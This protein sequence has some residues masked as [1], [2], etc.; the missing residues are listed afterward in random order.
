MLDH[1][2]DSLAAYQAAATF[3]RDAAGQERARE[4]AGGGLAEAFE[5]LGRAPLIEALRAGASGVRLVDGDLVVE[6]Q[7]VGEGAHLQVSWGGVPAIDAALPLEAAG[8][9]GLVPAGAWVEADAGAMEALGSALWVVETAQGPRLARQLRPSEAGGALPVRGLIPAVQVAE[10][11]SAAFRRAHGV[12][13]AYVAGAMAG[14]I[15]S[16]ALV[17]AMSESGLLAFY[18]SGGLPIEAVDAAVGRLAAR[19]GGR[20]WGANLLHNPVEPGV[21]MATVA[22]YLQHGVRAIEASAFM[23]LTPAVVRFRF[24]GAAEHGPRR[25]MAKVSRAEVAEPFL[26]PPPEP[27]LRECVAAGWLSEADARLA[28]TLPVAGDV[29]VEAD[30]GGHTDHRALTVCFPDV[31]ALRDRLVARFAYAEPPRVGAAGGLG[32]PKAVCA[33]FAMGADYV[34]TGSVNQCTPE[35]GTSDLV[36][37]MLA[38]AGPTDVASG[39][40]PDMFEL[41]AK[42]QVLSRGAMYAQRAQ[43]LYELYK[44]VGRLDAIPADERAKLEK[45]VFQR[46]LDEVWADTLA[47]WQQRDPAMA[48]RGLADERH[49]MALTFRWYLGM[50][51]RWARQ[52]D[53]ARKRDYQIWCG[54]AMGAFNQWVRGSALEPVA[55]RGVVAVADALLRGAAVE[56]RIDA[57]RRLGVPVAGLAARPPLSAG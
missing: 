2:L 33:A 17:A 13:A 42:V 48:E 50:T 49:R 44:S 25:V 46:P 52:G 28:A 45:Q 27:I 23:G 15:A 26:S 16:E 4:A 9:R 53:P 19:L 36:K 39:P 30:S 55:A 51:S 24:A 54:P 34:V 8:P 1:A 37:G 6:A 29:T 43:R 47:Y 3:A 20:P 7:R 12:R 10:L 31:L 5:A 14:G 18:G 11:G 22:C 56:A 32:N 41:G 38:E 35:A 40:A 21:E 57:A